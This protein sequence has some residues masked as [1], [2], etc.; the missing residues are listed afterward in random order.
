[1][2][3]N[4]R[5]K[6]KSGF[7]QRFPVFGWNDGREHITDNLYFAPETAENIVRIFSR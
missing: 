4:R 1:M 7:A 3:L 5:E 2:V 6:G